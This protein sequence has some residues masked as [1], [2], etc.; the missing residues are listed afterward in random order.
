MRVAIA[1]ILH[2][3]PPGT[4]PFTLSESQLGG[5]DILA[6]DAMPVLSPIVDAAGRRASGEPT[7]I[8]NAE[9]P[10]IEGVEALIIESSE[11]FDPS[12]LIKAWPGVRAAVVTLGVGI[13]Q[14]P[15]GYLNTEYDEITLDVSDTSRAVDVITRW[16]EH[17]RG[18]GIS[19]EERRQLEVLVGEVQKLVLAQNPTSYE[20]HDEIAQV[21]AAVDTIQAQLKAPRPA[22]R[23]ISWALSQFAAFAVGYAAGIASETTLP[24]LQELARTFM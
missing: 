6:G 10:F 22:R 16:L 7:E 20:L 9:T 5:G 24:H 8:I 1:E 12:A 2:V 21:Q 23:V 18:A 4:R 15:F 3:T 17:L 14:S 13:A 11:Q 19:H